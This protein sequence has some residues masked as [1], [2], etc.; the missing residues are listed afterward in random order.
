MSANSSRYIKILVPVIC[1]VFILTACEL[2]Y[3]SYIDEKEEDVL[4]LKVSINQTDGLK[5]QSS[6]A[7]IMTIEDNIDLQTAVVKILNNEGGEIVTEDSMPWDIHKES[8][9]KDFVFNDL[10]AGQKFWIK[11]ELKGVLYPDTEDESWVKVLYKG[12]AETPEITAGK[13]VEKTV[14]ARPVNA[15]ELTVDV[16]D[17]N[18]ERL[19]AS[20][21]DNIILYHPTLNDDNGAYE[22]KV[23]VGEN[24]LPVDFNNSELD[25]ISSRWHLKLEL[26][27]GELEPDYAEVL[28][29]PDE[30]KSVN[31]V[32]EKGQLNVT[33][34]KHT[35]LEAPT[36][37]KIEQEKFI[38][39]E[40]S[41]AESYVVYRTDNDNS[42]EVDAPAEIITEDNEIDLDQLDENG[43]Y[44]VRAYD[45]EGMSGSL[46]ESLNIEVENSD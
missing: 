33:V 34:D 36:D 31:L 39:Q 18:E 45:D 2:F 40:V 26:T 46:S 37:L 8:G 29:L 17:E 28:L 4:G 12:A 43:Y 10:E 21:V 41:D 44:W 15:A 11:V 1:L 7:G 24:D 14:S 16:V 32:V 23:D 42:A 19:E 9:G 6:G 27:E 20:Q 38:W 35:S 25:L 22:K 30:E 5:V 13:V 3:D